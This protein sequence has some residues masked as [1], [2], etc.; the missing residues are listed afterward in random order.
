MGTIWYTSINEWTAQK[1][2]DL[3]I[4]Y[5]SLMKHSQLLAVNVYFY[6]LDSSIPY[7]ICSMNAHY[8]GL[9]S[10][11]WFIEE[12]EKNIVTIETASHN[13]YQSSRA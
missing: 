11:D 10:V 9:T 4:C 5:Q 2:Y 3:Q 6:M 1:C 7:L 8:R 12:Q 13:Y